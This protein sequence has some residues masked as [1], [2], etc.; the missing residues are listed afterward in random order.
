MYYSHLVG[1]CGPALARNKPLLKCFSATIIWD[2]IFTRG[3]PKSVPAP[4]VNTVAAIMRKELLR[5][6]VLGHGFRRLGPLYL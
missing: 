1:I 3:G 2:E 6:V 4:S 5:A